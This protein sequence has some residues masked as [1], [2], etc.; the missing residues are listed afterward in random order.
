MKKKLS[1]NIEEKTITK[2]D[3]FVEEG[4]FRNKSHLIEFAINKFLENKKNGLQSCT[5]GNKFWL[6]CKG[7]KG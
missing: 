1:I 6:G 4:C 5:I 7:K 3:T 2:L